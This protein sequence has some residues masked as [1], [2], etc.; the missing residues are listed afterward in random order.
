MYTHTCT[1]ASPGIPIP[2]QCYFT[3][4]TKPANTS[5]PVSSQLNPAPF[6]T[7]DIPSSC[8]TAF[9]QSL[10]G[11]NLTPY[12][13]PYPAPPHGQA[14]SLERGSPVGPHSA[15]HTLGGPIILTASQ[16]PLNGDRNTA[17]R[18]PTAPYTLGG[19]QAHI[20]T[21]RKVGVPTAAKGHCLPWG[22]ASQVHSH[23]AG[24]PYCTCNW[25]CVPGTLPSQE[26][27]LLH[28][29]FLGGGRHPAPK[30]G[31][32][33]G[34]LIAPQHARRGGTPSTLPPRGG[35]LPHPRWA[36][37]ALPPPGSLLHPPNPGRG[38]LAHTVCAPQLPA[39]PATWSRC[40]PPPKLTSAACAASSAGNTVWVRCSRER[41]QTTQT[42]RRS[43][44]Q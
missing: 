22:V 4:K 38:S 19:K 25:G 14:C 21:P 5:L 18:V 9:G 1:K 12:C 8:P 23:P 29:P 37:G 27:S 17:G 16:V 43:C 42:A 6:C 41:W 20:C 24:C 3:Q 39:A 32:P 33:G 10:F 34:V 2:V 40:I 28:L 30:K 26:R 44:T 13:T 7:G 35:S 31:S 11:G 36:P 15:P